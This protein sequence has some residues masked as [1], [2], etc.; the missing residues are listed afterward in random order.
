MIRTLVTEING[1]VNILVNPTNG[2]SLPPRVQRLKE[3]GVARISFGSSIMK[4]TLALVNKIA[5]EVAASG[6]YDRYFESLQP[7]AGTA[8]AYKMAT[9]L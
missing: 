2:T 5:E 1:P 3:I 8:E 4:A 7:I 9:S 6:T